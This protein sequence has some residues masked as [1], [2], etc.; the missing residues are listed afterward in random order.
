[1]VAHHAHRTHL[2][3]RLLE[4]TLDNRLC[5]HFGDCGGCRS[6]DV[7][8]V[9]QCEAKGTALAELF[10][11]YWDG[12]VEVSPSPVI[13]HYRNKVDFNFAEMRYEEPPPKGFVREVVLGFKKQGK[14]FWPLD[15]SEC[16]ISSPDMG[17]LLD[18][19]R[20]WARSTGLRPF[21]SRGRKGF[22]K[23]LLVREGKRTG[24]RMVCLVTRPGECETDGFVSAV[25]DACDATSI[26]WIV[27][28]SFSPAM[29]VAEK[30]LLHGAPTI[31]EELHLGDDRF[32]FRISPESFFQTN[33][34]ATELLYSRIRDWAET[35]GM[36][37]LYDLYGGAGGIAFACHDLFERVVSVESVE[38]ATADGVFN[39]ARN[40]IGNVE[41][42]TASTEDYLRDRETP[43]DGAVILDPPRAGMHPK[44]LKR[45]L[46]DPPEHVLYIS[47]K[48]ERFC[49]EMEAFS[50][51]Y[52]IGA[53]EGIDLFP[54]TPHVE[55]IIR[56]DRKG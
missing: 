16:R 42:I 14:W 17:D 22:L 1:M 20:N 53:I 19:V 52:G 39:A 47:C 11:R 4:S 38:A 44:A 15:M 27:D 40:G 31:R 2:R 12:P 36:S 50:E 45:L 48:P 18:S 46:A 29:N 30:H 13:W 25:Q 43:L 49:E 37:V 23:M 5:T 28:D 32:S 35:V 7:P 21:N 26:Q 55:A 10:S 9:E 41:F 54:H 33:T 6:Q 24:E 3:E 34:L 8:Y 56:L 51:A